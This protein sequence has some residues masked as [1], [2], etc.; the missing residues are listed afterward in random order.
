MK[1]LELQQ[2]EI[3]LGPDL[4]AVALALSDELNT[5]KIDRVTILS[6]ARTLAAMHHDRD[7]VANAKK[8]YSIRSPKY[9]QELHRDSLYII[10]DS[11]SATNYQHSDVTT[12][13]MQFVL[14]PTPVGASSSSSSFNRDY[15]NHDHHD[16]K[17]SWSLVGTCL[18]SPSGHHHPDRIRGEG[19]APAFIY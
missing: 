8:I 19:A 2:S 6:H 1:Q 14:T 12:L 7:L 5:N 16:Q 18:E 9:K 15:Q 3:S 4:I 11:S 17:K 10:T 13:R